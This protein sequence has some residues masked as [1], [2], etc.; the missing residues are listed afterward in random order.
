MAR[1][2][3]TPA[4]PEKLGDYGNEVEKGA[5]TTVG[6]GYHADEVINDGNPLKR[7]LHGRHMQ[8]IAIGEEDKSLCSNN[9]LTLHCRREYWSGSI[10]GIW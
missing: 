5:I 9:Q 1:H 10:R 4:Y 6:T 3:P 7:E 2:D 8:M